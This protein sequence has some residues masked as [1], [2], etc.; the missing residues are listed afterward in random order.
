MRRLFA[1]AAAI[2][3][4]VVLSAQAPASSPLGGV[5]ALDR[6][7]SEL[8]RDIGFNPAWMAAASRETQGGGSGSSSTGGSGG[9]GRRGSSSGNGDRGAAGPFATH[10]ESY[11]DAQ[12]VKLM[13]A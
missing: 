8:P 13:T 7:K 4:S 12:R 5:W 6:A 1:L 3:S 2:V 9:R 11:E 10:Q